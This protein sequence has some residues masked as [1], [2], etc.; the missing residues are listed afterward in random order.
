MNDCTGG[1]AG[2]II[3]P[4]WIGLEQ[5]DWIKSRVSDGLDE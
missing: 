2:N 5:K 3:A 4:L 1:A